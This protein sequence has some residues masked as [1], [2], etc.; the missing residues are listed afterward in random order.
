M[1]LEAKLKK[2]RLK[3]LGGFYETETGCLFY[4]LHSKTFYQPC[5]GHHFH[6]KHLAIVKEIWATVMLKVSSGSRPFLQSDLC[7][8]WPGG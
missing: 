1:L 3:K 8:G 5:Q 7:G 6:L 4:K 2:A